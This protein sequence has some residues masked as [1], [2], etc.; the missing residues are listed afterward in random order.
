[1]RFTHSPLNSLV[2]SVTAFLSALTL[3]PM[4]VDGAYLT[5]VGLVVATSGVVGALGAVARAP[6]MLTILL[7]L[8]AML[9]LL[10]WNGLDRAATITGGTDTGPVGALV[11]LARS[12]ST[13][14][15]EGALPLPSETG[16]LWLIAAILALVTITLELLVNGLE[17]P[18]WAMAP[19]SVLYG[20]G[21]LAL[22]GEMSWRHFALV[23]VGYVAILLATTGFGSGRRAGTRAQ[24]GQFQASRVVVGVALAVVAALLALLLTPSVPMGPK[25]P[26]LEAGQDAPIQLS[27]PT[28][29]LNQNLNRPQE[30]EVLT[31]RTGTGEPTYL[32]TVAL[33]RLTTSGA[34]LVPM[35]LE[36]GGLGEISAPGT[37]IEIEVEMDFG[38]EYLPVPFAVESFQADGRWAHDP[39]TRAVVATGDDRLNQT[40]GL[41]YRARAVAPTPSLEEVSVA[42]AGADP[43]GNETLRVPEGIDPAVTTLTQEVVAGAADD[44]AKALAIQSYLRSEQFQY[45]L[46]APQSTSLDTISEFLLNTN[47][48]YCIHFASGMVTMARISGIPARMAVGFTPGEANEDGSFTVTTHNMHTWPELYFEGLGWVP[49][50]PTKS[51]ASPPEY[52]NPDV[53]STAEPSASPSPS[54]SPTSGETDLPE[55]T[56]TPTTQDGRG[57]DA[58]EPTSLAGLWIALGVAL[59]AA[60]PFLLRTGQRFWRLRAGQEPS[61]AAEAVW[62]EVR[63]T[64]IDLGIEWDDHTPTLAAA[65]MTK[66]MPLSSAP[67]LADIASTVERARFSRHGADVSTLAEQVRT[68]RKD[69]V[70]V[71]PGGSH[72]RAMFLPASL[73]RTRSGT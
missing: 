53:A 2:I 17:Q 28:I 64:F 44:G 48:G 54:P 39:N 8:A 19:L 6:R 3:Q 10:V 24:V 26:W 18:A 5:W 9:V 40:V 1:M 35:Q 73:L 11:A 21:A 15:R 7:Q 58:E 59:V 47:A 37:E 16:L 70:A 46:T 30:T 65:G 56:P 52:T 55:V 23:A 13:T 22:P 12:G 41:G 25:Q 49:F 36:T 33:T 69:L 51:V 60:L 43:A 27:D 32:R 72:A 34:Q 63:A 38:S 62:D 57:D 71:Q 67:V 4:L 42:A 14:V 31:Y 29:E 66:D 20:I 50:E 68:L 45:T 61:E